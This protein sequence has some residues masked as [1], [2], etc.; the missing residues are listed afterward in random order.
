MSRK[1]FL[2][3]L[4][5]ALIIYSVVSS[6]SFSGTF[7]EDLD[8]IL[9]LSLGEWSN[10]NPLI[11]AIF[12]L[13]GIFPLIYAALI[14]FDGTEQKISPYPFFIGS[15]GLGAFVLLPYF[16]LR[17]PNTTWNGEKSW[18][19]KILDSRL[20]AITSTIAVIVLLVWGITQ[21]NWSDFVTQW[22]STKFVHIM[23]L[24]FCL[25]CFLFIAILGD[26]LERRGVEQGI[27][28]SVAF[29]PLFGVLIYWCLRPQLPD[30]AVSPQS[31]AS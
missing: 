16:I 4:W 14:L 13:M 10:I 17:Q 28:S 18:F 7:Q 24:D 1:L 20:M 2:S 26:D 21:G 6:A 25:L 15:I 9:K 31:L 23:S 8:L 11:I 19:L 5:L 22:H 12:Y 29:I 27:L 3:F 30:T